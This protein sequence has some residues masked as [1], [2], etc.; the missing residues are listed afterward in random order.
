MEGKSADRNKIAE[1]FS[2]NFHLITTF[3]FITQK[4]RICKL[5]LKRIFR[6]HFHGN[7]MQMH[8]INAIVGLVQIN[9]RT[10]INSTIRGLVRV[11]RK[12]ILFFK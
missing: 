10:W 2:E 4:Y 11:E 7:V 1:F 6:C 8:H 3:G 9:K 5:Q 12:I